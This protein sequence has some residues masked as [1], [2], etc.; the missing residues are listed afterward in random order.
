M[1]EN[2]LIISGADESAPAPVAPFGEPLGAPQNEAQHAEL[3]GAAHFLDK[4]DARYP[5]TQMVAEEIYNLI[6]GNPFQVD[7]SSG[8]MRDESGRFVSPLAPGAVPHQAMERERVRRKAAEVRAREL[9]VAH[10][11]IEERLSTLNQLM[12][13][14]GLDPAAPQRQQHDQRQQQQSS[15]DGFVDPEID[16]F[17]AVAQLQQQN[18]R[19]QAERDEQ[20]FLEN[21]K[22]DMLKFAKLAPDFF[23][24]VEHLVQSRDRELEIMGMTDKQQR[25][26]QIAR[27]EKELMQ[28]AFAEGQSPAERL[29]ALARQ[30]GFGGGRQGQPQVRPNYDAQSVA[31]IQRTQQGQQASVSLSG[32]GGTGGAGL[33]V[34]QIADMPEDE[35][36]ALINKMGGLGSPSVRRAFGG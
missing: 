23:A 14:A 15:S 34:Q 25:I 17:A 4:A 12:Q 2:A 8:P 32:A 28:Q 24:G 27:E 3:V 6:G 13:A 10:A 18:S 21:A 30:R 35:F 29:Y 7:G 20:V 5:E 16:V 9:E 1:T 11:K 33:S 22:S 19:L 36:N 26:R 31:Q